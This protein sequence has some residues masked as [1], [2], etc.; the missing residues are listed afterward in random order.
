RAAASG[1]ALPGT[2]TAA[3]ILVPAIGTPDAL[4]KGRTVGSATAPV[5]LTV[6]SDFQCPA[7]RAFATTVEPRLIADYVTPGKLRI[8]Y[9]D[10]VIIGAESRVAAIASRCA[11]RQGA[12]WPY[13]DVLFANQGQENSGVLSASRLA[14]MAVAVGLTADAF[15]A[16]VGDE[17]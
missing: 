15:A 10:L 6:W 16:C 1:P 3:G 7:C 13:H 2:R 17:S 8:E 12:F 14:D 9:R 4:A 5:V 11:D